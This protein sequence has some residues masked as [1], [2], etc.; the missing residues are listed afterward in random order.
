MADPGSLT[1]LSRITNWLTRSIS[2][3]NPTGEKG[4]GGRADAGLG[5]ERARELGVGWKVAPCVTLPAGATTVL[6]QIEGPGVIRH[7]WMTCRESAWRSLLLRIYWDDEPS[8]SIEVPLGDFFCNG[9]GTFGQV[10][11]LPVVV[12]PRGGFNSYWE[13]PFQRRARMTIENLDE[14]EVTRFFYQVTYDLAD[15]S[16]DAGY[17]HCQWRRSNP[18]DFMRPHT[19]LEGV[20]GQG[21]YVGTY[22]AWA[23]HHN[24][25]WGEGELKFFVDGD[26]EFPTICGTGIEDYFGGAWG[27]A[28]PPGEQYECFTTPYLGMPQAIDDGGFRNSQPRFGLYRFHVVDAIRFC[29]GIRATVQALGW[30]PNRTYLPLRDDIASTCWWYQTEPHGDFPPPPALRDLETV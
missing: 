14:E 3:E 5:A 28:N 17:L 10:S 2:A 22:L 4:M 30:R 8:A 29:S 16:D 9:W 20:V 18:V 15:V 12:N 1:G 13:M 11:A 23:S 6:A 24:G 27:F 26:E 7:I 19:I 25:W 21:H